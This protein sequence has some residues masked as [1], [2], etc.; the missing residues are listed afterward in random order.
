MSLCHGQELIRDDL[1]EQCFVVDDGRELVD[2]T[3]EVVAFGLQLDP[4]ELCEP[5]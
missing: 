3:A 1:A 5:A 4:R 2:A